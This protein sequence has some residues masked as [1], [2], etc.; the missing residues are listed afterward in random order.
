MT[1]GGPA[2]RAGVRPGDAI[3]ALNGQPLASSTDLTRR[4]GQARP[5][6]RL[7]LEVLRDG[8]PLTLEIAAG[9]RPGEPATTRAGPAIQAGS[10][11][12]LSLAPLDAAARRRLGQ[13]AP[14]GVL[15]E[16]VAPASDAAARGLRRGDVITRVNGRE[17]KTPAEVRAAVDEVRRQGRTAVLL[18]VWRASQSRFVP[19]TL[20]ASTTR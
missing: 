3:V 12:G 11:L 2:D 5:G 10:V 17:A 6:E 13:D 4:V 20:E 7:R 16:R 15:I 14:A 19:L 9:E 8:R 18:R 1:P